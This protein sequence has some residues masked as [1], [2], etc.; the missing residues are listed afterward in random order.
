MAGEANFRMGEPTTKTKVVSKKRGTGTCFTWNFEESSE[1]NASRCVF[2]PLDGS[3]RFFLV[4]RY[5]L[6][7]KFEVIRYTIYT[8]YY[9]SPRILKKRVIGEHESKQDSRRQHDLQSLMGHFFPR[10][11]VGPT[12][13]EGGMKSH[14][15]T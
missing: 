3:I 2:L 10:K 15:K 9:N 7:L 11:C 12:S 14:R 4:S 5:T 1:S 13:L 8:V 6:S